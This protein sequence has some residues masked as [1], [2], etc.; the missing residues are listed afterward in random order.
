MEIIYNNT[1]P[2]IAQNKFNASADYYNQL[3]RETIMMETS[4]KSNMI[5]FQFGKMTKCYNA[6]YDSPAITK[7][8]YYEALTSD[9]NFSVG[10][11]YV[12]GEIIRQMSEDIHK[13]ILNIYN[14]LLFTKFIHS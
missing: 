13:E 6:P 9:K 7:Q 3:F 2:H 8:E 14:Y 10:W 12:T 1:T 11:D 5:T 4:M